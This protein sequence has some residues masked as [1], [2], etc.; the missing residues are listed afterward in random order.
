MKKLLIT[1]ILIVTSLVIIPKFIGSIAE[2]ER[3]RVL[4]E[5]NEIDG[6]TLTTSQ[7]TGGWFGADVVSEM[8][9]SLKGKDMTNVSIT[10][11]ESLSFGPVIITNKNWYLGLGYSTIKLKLSAIELDEGIVKTL[12]EK[13]N[14]GMLLDFNKDVTTFI[15]ID[16]INYQDADT[17]ITSEPASAQF[18]L[19][20]NKHVVGSFSCGEITIETEDERFVMDAVDMSTN[21]KITSSGDIA[22]T[23]IL[24]GNTTFNVAKINFYKN[25]S[26]VFSV[27]KTSLSSEVSLDNDLLSLVLNY[28]AKEIAT[29]GQSFN[30]LNADV[31]LTN[32]D[33]QALQKSNTTLAN[34]PVNTSG[35]GSSEDILQALS[36]IADK[37]FAKDP[38][39]KISDLSVVT[40]EG[41]IES[42]FTFHI[43]KDLLDTTNINVMTL[44]AA[45]EAE[46]KG[47]VPMAFLSKLGMAPMVDNLVEQ[48]YLSHKDNEIS[49]E[50]K[51]VN[52]K[53]TFN[54]KAF[55]L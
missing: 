13:L 42:E 45:L 8:N 1:L 31:L 6:I 38:N 9:L 15:N 54:G 19:S 7:Y 51:Y 39:L 41:K 14:V 4:E 43:N 44:V 21:Q 16:K 23:T 11:E 20:S 36:L 48:G 22:G 25:K 5:L 12:N 34:L 37:I 26:N 24:T 30:K 32:I 18:T 52:S 35:Q 3:K 53:L 40:E 46:A 47:K 33:I 27:E 55:Q 2:N 28:N 10:L 50:A 29:S 49:V 17:V